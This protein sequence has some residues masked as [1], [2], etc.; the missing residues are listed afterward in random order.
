MQARE[1]AETDAYRDWWKEYQENNK[2]VNARNAAEDTE[3][4]FKE[5]M[6]GMEKDWGNSP[7]LMQPMQRMLDQMRANALGK[8]QDYSTR[9]E[10]QYAQQTNKAR[11]MQ[12]ID[13]AED[14]AISDAEIARAFQGH[15]MAVRLA[16]G[17]TA[18]PETGVMGGGRNVDAVLH[19][20]MAM[21]RNA[22]LNAT[23]ARL[24]FLSFDQLDGAANSRLLSPG[25]RE[26]L[27]SSIISEKEK[28]IIN[29]AHNNPEAALQAIRGNTG[30]G[31]ASGAKLPENVRNL[32]IEEANRRGIDP[33]LALALVAVE[34]G[35]R[36]DA[37]SPVG[38]RGV[39]QL[40][41]GTAKE[42]GV[43]PDD[44]AQNIRGG[45]TYLEQMYNRYG[46]DMR[47]AL[48][49]YNW[50]PGNVDSY[51][52]NGHGIKTERNPNGVVPQE[53]Q[54]YLEKLLGVEGGY[55]KFSPSESMR[56]ERQVFQIAGTMAFEGIRDAVLSSDLPM[57]RW[58][59]AVYAHATEDY[60]PEIRD[61]VV[62]HWNRE[63]A[64]HVEA[65]KH[66]DAGIIYEFFDV[67]EGR[68]YADI[69]AA[70][71]DQHQTLKDTGLSVDGFVL[72]QR[73]VNNY[74]LI[75]VENLKAR[76]E[77]LNAIA[78]GNFKKREDVI[79]AA[80]S[81]GLAP[82]QIKEVM[83]SFDSGSLEGVVHKNRTL[84]NNKLTEYIRG[85]RSLTK[86]FDK[87]PWAWTEAVRSQLPR[88]VT[89]HTPQMIMEACRIVTTT[90]GLVDAVKNGR[91]AGFRIS[92]VSSEEYRQA[93]D[94]LRM[95][96]PGREPTRDEVLVRIGRNKGIR[97]PVAGH[98][99]DAAD[100]VPH[101]R[102]RFEVMSGNEG[103]W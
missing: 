62:R 102:R 44:M 55:G 75:T 59:S 17:Q 33:D 30:R 20:E 103:V 94:E 3:K 61:E 29:M 22:R 67:L 85:D 80:L 11:L 101:G 60:Q 14:P 51:L 8:A 57:E 25:D 96:N 69:L 16:A 38:A 89:D 70:F 35:G 46:G 1:V 28:R 5:R 13:M 74:D 97:G 50:G 86:S 48:M 2:G 72:L 83:G 32:V 9:E 45:M 82:S 39:M 43:D 47:L 65:R 88:D 4:F 10:E 84:I 15:S 54:R 92:G 98:G 19:G 79:S 40:M 41:P 77:L 63:K 23:Q 95:E 49:A 27:H 71:N 7:W 42:L 93:E 99:P 58:D 87:Y 81:G 36:Q 12:I 91:L 66:R 34:S 78:D 68:P 90:P 24:P 53:T 31:R 76:E 52:R 100:A 73:A 26:R 18:D 6:A 56:L 37:V 21:L 64:F